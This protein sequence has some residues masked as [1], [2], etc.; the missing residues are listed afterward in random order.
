MRH[1]TINL[2]PSNPSHRYLNFFSMILPSN[3]GFFGNDDPM[4]IQVFDE[5][6]NFIGGEW[7]VM[8]NQIYDAGTEI[9]DEIAA[10]VPV[11]GQAAPNTGTTENGVIAKHPGFIPGGPIQTAFANTVF[12]SA[13]Y[14]VFYVKIERIPEDHTTVEFRIQSYAPEQGTLLTPFWLGLHDGSFDLFNPGEAV[15][16]IIERVAED[17]DPETLIEAFIANTLDAWNGL[18]TGPQ[19][20]SGPPLF[21]PHQQNSLFVN[22]DANNP[23]HSY[24]SYLAMILPSNDAFVGNAEPMAHQV[25]SYGSVIESDIWITG[26]DVWD[27]GTEVNDEAPENVPVL[28]QA[29][30]NTGT[31]ENGVATQHPGFIAGGNVLSNFP[32]ADFTS[33]DYKVA[34]ISVIHRFNPW[35]GLPMNPEG[36]R[37]SPTF[38]IVDD[39]N[40][41]WLHHRHHGSLFIPEGGNFEGFWL[42]NPQGDF[43]WFFTSADYYPQVYRLTD[44]TWYRYQERTASPRLFENVSTGEVVEFE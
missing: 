26:A 1:R 32:N 28:G 39:G 2:D 41:P 21:F 12:D 9:N 16:P 27:A 8:G 4:T 36:L 37:D 38:G 22:I 10:N 40:Y 15:S 14:G 44:E 3:D 17:G 23:S 29:A 43:G 7:A 11:L 42:Y 18:L 24:L 34:K 19:N 5:N 33:E 25:A 6:G 20:P 31:D 13:E 30:P 35:D